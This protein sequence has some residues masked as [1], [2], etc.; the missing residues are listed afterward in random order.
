MSEAFKKR[1]DKAKEILQKK[2]VTGLVLFPGVE[3]FYLTGF[4]IGLSERP[5]A[6]LIPFN[7]EP[8]FV[9]PELEAELRGQ[10]PW[11]HQV[12]TWREEEDAIKLLA[13]TLRSKGLSKAKIGVCET[14]PWGWVKRLE[15]NLPTAQFVDASEAV[16]SLR[17]VK[18]TEELDYIKK[19]CEITDKALRKAFQNLREGITEIELNSIISDEME[20]L[21]GKIQ[22]GIVLFGGRAA[23]PHGTLSDRKLKRGDVILVDTGSSFKD[24]YSDITRTVVFGKPTERQRRIWDNVLKANKAAFDA[25]EPG[26]TCEEADKVARKVISDAG[27]GEYFIHRL[28]HG[29]GLQGHEHPYLVGGNK[30]RL[31][32]GMTFSIEPG[33]YIVGEIGVRT[34]DTALCTRDGCE[35]L[36]HLE[37]S[38]EA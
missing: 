38:I 19:A 34:E 14:S 13:E 2:G 32:A 31:E 8:V 24:Y 21:G 11:I 36:T 29:I 10:K 26:T 23:L 15:K 20:N 4:K 12:V 27:F 33:I 28:G 5:S 1:A 35:S 7:D 25:I 22:F 37:R 6:A 16:N 9:V 3:I 17:M 30:L 18:S